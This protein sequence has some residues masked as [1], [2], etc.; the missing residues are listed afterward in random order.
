MGE[1]MDETLKKKRYL[2]GFITHKYPDTPFSFAKGLI[3]K[4]NNVEPPIQPYESYVQVA[5]ALNEEDLDKRFQNEYSS[6]WGQLGH[7]YDLIHWASGGLYWDNELKEQREK[8][9][10]NGPTEFTMHVWK[11]IDDHTYE[12][13]CDWTFQGV[14]WQNVYH[15]SYD[16]GASDC[17]GQ[18]HFTFEKKVKNLD[19]KPMK[20]DFPKEIKYPGLYLGRLMVEHAK[21][22]QLVEKD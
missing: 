16:S 14:K 8:G 18:A 5:V 11:E 4:L 17:C 10:F 21:P 7:C 1:M 6:L 15:M 13:L 22:V 3:A 9:S 12:S 19:Y 20:A 2:H